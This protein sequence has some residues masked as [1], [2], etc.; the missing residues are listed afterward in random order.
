MQVRT[1]VNI[2]SLARPGAY[3]KRQLFLFYHVESYEQVSTTLT[4]IFLMLKSFVCL[5]IDMEIAPSTE[6]LL[7]T[8]QLPEDIFFVIFHWAASND[9]GEKHNSL[10]PYFTPWTLAS[11]CRRWRA[12]ALSTPTL[13]STI[14]LPMK[15]IVPQPLEIVQTKLRLVLER[16]SPSDLDVVISE[17]QNR[18]QNSSPLSLSLLL[19][20]IRQSAGRWRSLNVD[21]SVSFLNEVG[22]YSLPHLRKLEVTSWRR[23]REYPVEPDD[24]S[25]VFVDAPQLRDVGM[26]YP[27][28]LDLAWGRIRYMTCVSSVLP[29]LPVMLRL[30]ILHLDDSTFAEHSNAWQTQSMTRRAFPSL[31]TIHIKGFDSLNVPSAVKQVI[32]APVLR[33]FVLD[34]RHYEGRLDLGLDGVTNLSIYSNAPWPAI[35]TFFTTTTL[36]TALYLHGATVTSRA[37]QG[38]GQSYLPHLESLR[39]DLRIVET[40]AEE[41][42]GMLEARAC[43]SFLQRVEE[44]I[45][46][47]RDVVEPCTIETLDLEN[48]LMQRWDALKENI[49]V[50][51]VE[52][53][54]F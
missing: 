17:Q 30:E 14:S 4:L 40:M 28:G 2:R 21:G 33:T 11:V 7:A 20:I 53:N 45:F 54:V 48:Q 42:F 5:R 51:Y 29:T 6:I 41:L 12:L 1:E 9:T 24:V 22:S 46:V 31:H 47:R 49:D 13:W 32:S 35:S 39:F 19:L 50:R 3:P 16:S 34:L 52:E 18:Q 26:G 37:L 8:S 36:V 23:Y 27:I 44:I 10:C 25:A 43:S 38:I 15:H